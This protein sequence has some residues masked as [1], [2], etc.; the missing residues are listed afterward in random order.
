M[1]TSRGSTQSDAPKLSYAPPC[2][3]VPNIRHLHGIVRRAAVPLAQIQDSARCAAK[4][5]ASGRHSP[6]MIPACPPIG[7]RC[8]S[9][10]CGI[11]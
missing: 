1:S 2:T 10:R 3:G 6:S 7:T 4:P 8:Q 9:A 5:I 11:G